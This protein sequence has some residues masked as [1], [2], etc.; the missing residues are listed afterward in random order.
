MIDIADLLLFLSLSW[1]E[2][3]RRAMIVIQTKATEATRAAPKLTLASQPAVSLT[4]ARTGATLSQK[5]RLW[6]IPAKLLGKA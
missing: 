3:V 6:M 4:L 1:E 2:A 5:E